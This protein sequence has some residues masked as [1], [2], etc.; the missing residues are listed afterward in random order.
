MGFGALLAG[1]GKQRENKQTSGK[2]WLSTT[3]SEQGGENLA[4]AADSHLFLPALGS[5]ALAPGAA[6]KPAEMPGL[7]FPRRAFLLVLAP[8]DGP[9]ILA[10]RLAAVSLVGGQKIELPLDMERDGTP[11]LLVTLDGLERDPQQ[12]GQRLLGFSQLRS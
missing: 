7:E 3:E 10:L 11:S 9:A 1:K 8:F 5:G 12:L 4:L 2:T 6:E